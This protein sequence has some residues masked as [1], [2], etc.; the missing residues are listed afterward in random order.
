MLMARTIFDHLLAARRDELD[1]CA[2]DIESLCASYLM[3]DN[4]YDF[5]SSLIKW[6]TFMPVTL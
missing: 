3:D 2:C 1:A 6:D 4:G 5:A